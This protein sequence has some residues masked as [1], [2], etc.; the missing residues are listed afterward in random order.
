MEKIRFRDVLI[1]FVVFFALMG[2][3][4]EVAKDYKPWPAIIIMWPMFTTL[5]IGVVLYGREKGR[6]AR[7]VEALMAG[8]DVPAFRQTPADRQ[9]LRVVGTLSAFGET[10]RAPFSGT[11]SLFYF[12]TAGHV[13]PRLSNQSSPG[14]VQR[15]P[16]VVPDYEGYGRVPCYVRGPAGDFKL[17]RYPNYLTGFSGFQSTSNIMGDQW[18]RFLSETQFSKLDGYRL[19]ALTGFASEFESASCLDLQYG[20]PNQPSFEVTESAIAPGTLVIAEGRYSRSKNALTGT[21]S[22]TAVNE[23]TVRQF[24]NTGKGSI[25]VA[26]TLILIATGLAALIIL[27]T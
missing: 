3:S 2:L 6:E 18:S 27:I 26:I 23:V 4:Y 13:D 8:R 15:G 16:V 9:R 17:L 10:M 20:R 5:A 22:L 1:L 19:G 11:D 21:I 7:V 24:Q 25:P 12:Y 14:Q